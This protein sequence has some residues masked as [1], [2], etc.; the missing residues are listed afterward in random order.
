ME[1]ELSC[2]H[3]KEIRLRLGWSVAELARRLSL[4]TEEVISLENNSDF[5]PAQFRSAFADLLRFADDYSSKISMDPFAEKVMSKNRL[6]QVTGSALFHLQ[7]KD[8][9]D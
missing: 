8:F 5:L 2:L 7:E 6:S 9:V 1:S 4:S 3:L